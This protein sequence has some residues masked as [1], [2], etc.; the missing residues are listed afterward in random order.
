MAWHHQHK[1][2]TRQRILSSA[3]RLF[4][5]KG[6]DHV[7][8]DEV[9]ADAGL[10]RGAFYAHFKN[11]SELYAKA[12]VAG[13][14]QAAEQYSSDAP[15]DEIVDRYLSIDHVQ[16]VHTHCP[17]AF[18]T[19]DISQRDTQVRHA[20]TRVFNGLVARLQQG[21]TCREKAIQQAI[22][23]VGGVAI[24][25]ALDDPELV[26]ELLNV[27]RQLSPLKTA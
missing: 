16:G 23:M 1:Q 3:A 25:R 27:C 6:F 2:Q 8:I 10:T 4:A 26:D 20:Y 19:S 13:A 11:K 22:L 24:S 21:D 12:I 15:A 9:M 17:L 7:G 5:Q 18:L 14:L